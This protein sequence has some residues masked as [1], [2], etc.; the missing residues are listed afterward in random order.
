[1]ISRDASRVQWMV[2]AREA[3]SDVV[4][5]PVRCALMSGLT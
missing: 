3:L 5:D 4:K 1:L 2:F